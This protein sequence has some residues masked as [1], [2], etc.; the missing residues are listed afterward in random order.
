MNRLFQAV[1][2][3][4]LEFYLEANEIFYRAADGRLDAVL[5][6]NDFGSQNALNPPPGVRHVCMVLR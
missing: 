2:D 1:I 4:I 5:I 6:G 3:R